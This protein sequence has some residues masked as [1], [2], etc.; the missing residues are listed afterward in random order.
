[1]SLFQTKLVFSFLIN[2]LENVSENGQD[3]FILLLVKSS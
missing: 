2:R 3:I 1:M